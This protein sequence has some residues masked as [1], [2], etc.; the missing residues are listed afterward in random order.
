MRKVT[1]CDNPNHR[2]K[3]ACKM[4]KKCKKMMCKH[5][6]AVA[7]TD[8]QGNPAGYLCLECKE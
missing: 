6:P 2:L 5:C 1:V 7:T 8:S 3:P 4:C